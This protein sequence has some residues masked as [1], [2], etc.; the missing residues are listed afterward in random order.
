MYENDGGT[1]VLLYGD[2]W[3]THILIGDLNDINIKNKH[4]DWIVQMIREINNSGFAFPWGNGQG[5]ISNNQNISSFIYIFAIKCDGK[6]NK[7]LFVLNSDF[8]SKREN[9]F[10]LL[11]SSLYKYADKHQALTLTYRKEGSWSV[12]DGIW[13]VDKTKSY[14]WPPSIPC[15]FQQTTIAWGYGYPSLVEEKENF[16]IKFEDGNGHNVFFY[17]LCSPDDKK[18]LEAKSKAVALLSKDYLDKS[19]G[20]SI[21]YKPGNITEICEYTWLLYLTEQG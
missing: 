10:K 19:I 7:A 9:D 5:L 4:P 21:V 17:H 1:D 8:V 16:V 6:R 13:K 15:I 18:L 2:Y 14:L 20:Y 3:I 11:I 12:I